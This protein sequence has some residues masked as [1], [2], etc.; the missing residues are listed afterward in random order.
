MALSDKTPR[1]VDEALVDQLVEEAKQAKTLK[2][3]IYDS[4][5]VPVWVLDILIVVLCVVLFCIILFK[6]V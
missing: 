1:K 3:Q 2:E 6:R 4:I 5:N